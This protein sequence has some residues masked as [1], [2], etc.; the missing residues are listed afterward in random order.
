MEKKKVLVAVGIG[1]GALL[2]LAVCGLVLIFAVL[3]PQAK[4]TTSI[5]GEETA[6][7]KIANTVG[8]AGVKELK[9]EE[10]QKKLWEET[11]TNMGE[12]EEWEMKGTVDEDGSEMEMSVKLQGEDMEMYMKTSYEGTDFS[13]HIVTLGEYLYYGVNDKGV[14]MLKDTETSEEMTSE[15]DV[16]ELKESFGDSD[17]NSENIEY[18]G[19]ETVGT[20]KY[21][22]F[23]MKDDKSTVWVDGMSKLPVKVE[24]E[25]GT[26]MTLTFTDVEISEPEGYED[27]SNLS[28]EEQGMKLMEIIFGAMDMGDY[29]DYDYE[30]ETDWETE[31]YEW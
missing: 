25:N 3:I 10:D 30:D 31:E 15:F 18:K 20:K 16:E 11:M 28:E 5:D 6:I 29:E 12:Q 27:I 21:H 19:V 14:K 24:D 1:C 26:A 22:T 23:Y 17:W 4:K 9:T 2:L 13:M 7:E 8:Y